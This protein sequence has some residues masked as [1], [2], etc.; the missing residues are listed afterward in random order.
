[1]SDVIG[2]IPA[3][4]E[5]KRV[6]PLPCSKELYPI[7]FCRSADQES[8]PKVACH[9]LLDQMRVAGVSRTYIILRHGKWD[10]PAYLQDGHL[11]GM[12]LAYL[13][14]RLCYG[15]PYTVDQ[16]YAFVQNNTVAFG[17]PDI[18]FES[19]NP[20]GQLL[21]AQKFSQAD[22]I[23]G[24][25]PGDHAQKLDMVDCDEAG[26]VRGIVSRPNRTHLRQTWGIAVW[27]PSFTHFLHRYLAELAAPKREPCMGE[28]FQAGL[29]YGLRI[30]GLAVSTEPYVDIGTPEDLMKT[31]RHWVTKESKPLSNS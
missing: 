21:E 1:M 22:I 15:V 28:A 23:L 27:R 31:V 25:F 2:I 18:L 20:F 13:I 30:E 29:Q 26:R 24:L 4:G 14:A 19:E 7:G 11:I 8:R 10:I 3:A 9:Y 5:A 17:F 12:P 16:A 6:S